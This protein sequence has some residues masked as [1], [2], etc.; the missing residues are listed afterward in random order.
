MRDDAGVKR[1][2]MTTS[3]VHETALGL[4][5]NI[6]PG[7]A[8]DAGS[9]QGA[10]TENLLERGFPVVMMDRDASFARSRPEG[11][12]LVVVDLNYGVPFREGCVDH[13]FAIEV[14]EHLWN[15]Y[16]FIGEA[17][18]VLRGGGTFTMST[19]N[20]ENVWQKII[21]LL[22]GRFLYFKPQSVNAEGEHFSPI[23][24]TSLRAYSKK[25]F[26]LMSVRYNAF[27]IPFIGK[28]GFLKQMT[29]I[30]S[31]KNRKFLGEIAIYQFKKRPESSI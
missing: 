21:Y 18:R 30:T 12:D 20:V 2:P 23:F 1:Q 4:T 14:V 19:P 5:D 17:G 16:G 31:L 25:L 3:F 11:T 29:Q 28:R 6:T 15:P 24:D 8:I 7:L 13:L 9:G 10:F 26:E 22:T 27:F